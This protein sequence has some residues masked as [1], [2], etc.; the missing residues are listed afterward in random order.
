MISII[1][2][3]YNSASTIVETLESIRV[4]TYTDYEVIVVDDCSRD[5]TVKVVKEWISEKMT[6][7]PLRGEGGG[8]GGQNR[9][10]TPHLNPLPQGERKDGNHIPR[11]TVSST[12]WSVISL[13]EN[14][15]PAAARNRGIQ[16]A[17]GD[18]IAFLD[19][20][21]IWLP[22][23][24][25]LQMR[26]AAEHPEVVLWCGETVGFQGEAN[27]LLV[28]SYS[29][30]GNS[31]TNQS[32]ITNDRAAG[33]PNNQ[34]PITNNDLRAIRLEDLALHNPIA[35]STVLVK[36]EVLLAV[37]GFDTQFRG[38]EDYDL[39]LRVAGW[40]EAPGGRT[41]CEPRERGDPE[42]EISGAK[43]SSGTNHAPHFAPGSD[44][45]RPPEEISLRSN[46][47]GTPSV[48]LAK[49]GL[50][51]IVFS[52]TPVS[53]YRQVP[54]SLSLDD[55]TFLPQV[56]RVIDKAFG[57]GGALAQ[58]QH[59]KWLAKS[60][61]YWSGSWMAFSRGDRRTAIRL[62]W[63]AWWLNRK[64]EMPLKRAWFRLLFRYFCG[65]R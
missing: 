29:L 62:W 27:P 13:P 46:V 17:H 7:S 43:R 25:E 42:V 50:G 45:P 19:A 26:L 10:N 5:D 24:L 57:S 39:W 63:K 15:G 34:E 18:W 12:S 11:F 38:P 53:R 58:L 51:S 22:H 60:T 55:R 16:E 44:K 32:P 64:A 37:G 14:A 6:P 61:Q 41:L 36:R 47:Y 20:D 28:N 33:T 56:L 2:P 1:I 49:E 23:K 52:P 8:E 54:G 59:F 9:E 31:T 65:R 30:F 21:Y 35:T 40:C 48:A 4:Q 3:A